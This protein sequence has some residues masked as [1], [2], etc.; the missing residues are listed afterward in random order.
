MKILILANNDIGLYKFRKELLES[1]CSKYKVYVSCPYGDFMEKIKS[2]GCKYICQEVDRR[3]TNPITDFKQL[4]GYIGLIHKIVPDI[5]L[6]YTIKPN[7][8]GGIACQIT[9]TPYIANVTGLGTSIENGGL[10]QIITTNLYKIGLRKA[11]CVFFQNKNNGRLFL[12]QHIVKKHARLIPGSGVNTEEH[13]FEEYPS[14]QN[15][16]RFL[17]VGRIMKDKGINELLSAMDSLHDDFTDISLDIVGEYDEDYSE[18]INNAVEKGYVRYHGR[19]EDVHPFYK[20][21]H[22]V[23]LPSYHEGMANV[24]LEAASTGRPLIASD[25]PGCKETFDEGKTGFGCEAKS[26]N[27]L[28][29]AIKKFISLSHE[30]K[31]TMGKEGRKKI[32][33]QFNRS[34][35][36]NAY[37]N[38]I[39]KIVRK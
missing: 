37:L 38:E 19:Q 25:I 6:T 31:T 21:C 13:K 10:M 12:K 11:N 22:C 39:Y 36:I 17:F 26:I 23:I 3:G 14:E 16:L 35:I 30:E 33:S 8:Y 27:S 15:G 9:H 7:V 34:I 18:I 20:N 28:A 32:Q 2:L 5:V 24:L 4:I 29:D 1:L